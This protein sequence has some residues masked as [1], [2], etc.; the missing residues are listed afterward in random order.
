[1]STQLFWFAARA[2]GIVAWALAA[3][4]VVWGIVGLYLL[5]AVELTS[6]A[7]AGLPRGLW[8]RVHYASFAVYAATTVHGLAA[9]TDASSPAFLVANALVAGLV[10]G[11]ATARF[12]SP[13]RRAGTIHPARVRTARPAR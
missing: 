12:L 2:S 7:R 1:V 11:L 13:P 10:V 4:S 3:G 6:L 8:R 9:G 5:L